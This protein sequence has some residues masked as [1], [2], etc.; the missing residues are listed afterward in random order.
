MELIP[1][2]DL[3]DGRVVRLTQGRYDDVTVYADDP[4][5]E[6]ARFVREGAARLHVVDLEG[7]RSGTPAHRSVIERIVRETSIS[8]QVGGGIRDRVTADAWL[9]AGVD[10]VVLGTAV[11]A[12]PDWVRALAEDHGRHVVI[13]LDARNGEVA[14]DGWTKS[15]GVR[16]DD[17]AREVDG[18]G[19]GTILYTDIDRDGTRRGPAVEATAALQG[20]VRATVIASGG[21]GALE[22]LR[23]LRAANVRAAVC[24]RALYGGAFTLAEGL[25]AAAGA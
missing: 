24:G 18:W 25:A 23:A 19:V 4:V 5:A 15:S 16:V 2:I 11:I 20:I 10:R 3:L 21:I 7:A 1:A 17:I 6:A 14:I 8:V 13:A 22:D 12:S 9:A